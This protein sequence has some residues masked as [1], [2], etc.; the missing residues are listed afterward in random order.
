MISHEHRCIFIHI[1]K[2]AGNSVNRVFDIGW[3]DH[4][5]LQR[6]HAELPPEIL[7][8]YFKFAI[9]RNPWDR[10]FSDYNY[11]LKK[12]R[13][14]DSKLFVFT[15]GGSRR[16]FAA[17]VEAA[18]SAA[19]GIPAQKWGGEVSGHI[20]RWSPQFD[21]ISLDGRLGVDFVARLEQLPAD[22][23]TV[24]HRLGLPPTRLPHRNRRLHWHYSHYYDRATREI[25]AR[26][27]ARDIEEFDYEF[28]DTILRLAM[29]WPFA[30]AAPSGAEAAGDERAALKDGPGEDETVQR[31]HVNFGG[32]PRRTWTRRPI[33]ALAAGLALLLGAW[34][35]APASD[36]SI[37]T[38]TATLSRETGR[39]PRAMVLQ[40]VR[41]PRPA[42]DGVLNRFL[43]FVRGDA[44]VQLV[45]VSS[46]PGTVT[47]LLVPT[48]GEPKAHSTLRRAP[49][50]LSWAGAR[51][52]DEFDDRPPPPPRREVSVN[53]FRR[54]RAD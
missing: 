10:L 23:R 20:H 14:A 17:W 24:C 35:M 22:F 9:V 50:S 31:T 5:D 37:V 7:G 27:Y 45:V 3:Q 21:W 46:F 8:R 12:S 48:E 18:L 6:Y 38:E 28:E 25:V 36:A 30:A 26:Y 2:T 4:K 19:H 52:L 15:A 47:V 42:S 41:P 51:T 11:Q 16:S 49:R 33:T 40:L 32:F 44:S 53:P 39:L 13:P 43:R 34:T 1:P 29:S 54:Q